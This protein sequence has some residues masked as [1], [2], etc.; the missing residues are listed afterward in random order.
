MPGGNADFILSGMDAAY[1]EQPDVPQ[2]AS[3]REQGAI[4]EDEYRL[5][6]ST[7]AK[8]ASRR[9]RMEVERLATLRVQGAITD[10]EYRDRRRH[11]ATRLEAAANEKEQ[12]L[13][14]KTKLD[15]SVGRIGFAL[16][17]V[18]T[19]AAIWNVILYE[20]DPYSDDPLVLWLMA[21]SFLLGPVALAALISALN[22]M[23]RSQQP[24]PWQDTA[25]VI[26]GLIIAAVGA[27][28]AGYLFLMGM[29]SNLA[30]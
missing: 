29:A 3:L 28:A 9:F 4:T 12:R 19:A 1:S 6:R 2:L 16:V 22:R 24:V 25:L 27:V 21:A 23:D 18:A 30:G 15:L 26:A 20:R 10:E 13:R 14:R 8:E 5:A 11:C 7:A 17:C